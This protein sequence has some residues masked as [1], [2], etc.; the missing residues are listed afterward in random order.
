[1]SHSGGNM[2]VPLWDSMDLI[3]QLM[4][5]RV[6]LLSF[7]LWCKCFALHD[8]L[9]RR[10]INFLP[11]RTTLAQKTSLPIIDSR[12]LFEHV[13]RSRQVDNSALMSASLSC[14]M[15]SC[16]RIVSTTI[17][18]YSMTLLGPSVFKCCTSKPASPLVRTIIC[19][20]L[21]PLIFDPTT[22]IES[23]M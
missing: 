9:I 7:T 4:S 10:P 2:A 6:S 11:S 3:H 14:E 1:M 15:R 17:P 12:S 16:F 5:A 13:F 18:V 8:A 20:F 21:W 23:S 22:D 19:K